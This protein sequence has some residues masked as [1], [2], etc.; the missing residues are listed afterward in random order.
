MVKSFSELKKNRQTSFEKLTQ[1]L[2]QLAKGQTFNDED[3]RFW[4]PTVDKDGNGYAVIRFLPVSPKDE[5]LKGEEA[6]PFVMMWDH[7]FQGPGGWYIEKSLSSIQ[8]N[9]PASEYNTMLWNRNK[10]GDRDFVSGTQG[11]SGSKRRLQ[12]YSNILVVEDSAKP[13]NNGKM[14]LYKYGKKI[15]DKVNEAANPKFPDE[16]PVDAFDMWEGANFKLKIRKYEGHRNYDKSEFDKP[17]A[18]IVGQDGKPDEKAMEAIWA[19]E[20]SLLEFLV[21]T[22]F[23]TYAELKAKLNRV[24]GLEGA[25]GSA[26][27]SATVEEEAPVASKPLPTKTPSAKDET[28]PWVAPADSADDDAELAEFQ[29]LVN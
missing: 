4:Q 16:K 5:E 9:D 29:K 8:Q 27:R 10:P 20:Y 28:P 15:F 13:E 3:A 11:K 2:N 1:K 14:F 22:N 7:G 24:L 12:Y 25:F 23:K 18:L 6:V 26:D 17:S 19:S 21:P